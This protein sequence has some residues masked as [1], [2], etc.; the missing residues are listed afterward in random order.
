MLIEKS[1]N[2]TDYCENII[3]ANFID[4]PTEVN[5]FNYNLQ[6]SNETIIGKIDSINNEIL[7]TSQLSLFD[8]NYLFF[9][10]KKNEKS[11]LEVITLVDLL[12]YRTYRDNNY[13]EGLKVLMKFKSDFFKLKQYGLNLNFNKFSNARN[14]LDS[15]EETKYNF[16][17][18]TQL[19]NIERL[20]KFSQMNEEDFRLWKN[21]LSKYSLI[22]KENSYIQNIHEIIFGNNLVES[23]EKFDDQ[24]SVDYKL[25]ENQAST[26]I[27]IYPNPNFG[28]FNL[29]VSAKKEG[30]L[31][32][33]YDKNGNKV[34]ERKI[35][36]QMSLVDLTHLEKGIYFIK[37]SNDIK[38]VLIN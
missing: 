21:Q 26:K 15:L 23:L 32:Y 20:D 36:N 30:E 8:K 5:I 10:N 24:N 6:I 38:K 2:H 27:R 4:N 29:V 25:N 33:I 19:L 7:K 37:Y 3:G 9:E 17:K 34:Y 14:I 12:L 11:E 16:F 13:N 28:V 18:E 1:L 22:S 35:Q 31:I